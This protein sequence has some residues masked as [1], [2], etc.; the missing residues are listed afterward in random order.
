MTHHASSLHYSVNI[1]QRPCVTVTNGGLP[2]R[3]PGL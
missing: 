1:I 3:Y 2:A